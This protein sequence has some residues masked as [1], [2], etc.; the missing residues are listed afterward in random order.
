[1]RVLLLLIIVVLLENC[2]NSTDKSPKHNNTQQKTPNKI[3]LSSTA[4]VENLIDSSIL[5]VPANTSQK[6]ESRFPQLTK[7]IN[8]K[9]Y[10][11]FSALY[12]LKNDSLRVELIYD[13]SE[14]KLR[15]SLDVAEIKSCSHSN[16][17]FSLWD[18]ILS[19]KLNSKKESG[20]SDDS[21]WDYSNLP[22]EIYNRESY[23][24]YIGSY[25]YD[26]HWDVNDSSCVALSIYKS[27]DEE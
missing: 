22:K 18:S 14:T 25:T 7:N 1:M 27:V 26:L 6:L 8:K 10:Q 16:E 13:S 4:I 2:N 15:D 3:F 24:W 20:K 21:K 5:W 23:H 12:A 17:Y 11:T 9:Y 19:K